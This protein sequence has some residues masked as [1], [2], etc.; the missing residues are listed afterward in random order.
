MAPLENAIILA[1]GEKRLKWFQALMSGYWPVDLP[2]NP[3]AP[4]MDRKLA[5]LYRVPEVKRDREVKAPVTIDKLD[6]IMAVWERGIRA[7]RA[8]LDPEACAKI[9]RKISYA[10]EDDPDMVIP[11]LIPDDPSSGM[12]K[13]LGCEDLSPIWEKISIEKIRRSRN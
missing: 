11:L 9:I 7:L 1:D 8:Q 12:P 6:A 5:L 4:E 10:V 3:L 2:E 13:L